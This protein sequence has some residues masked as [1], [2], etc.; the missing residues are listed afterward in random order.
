MAATL[1][2][3]GRIKRGYLG[4]RSQTVEI[5]SEAQTS[6]KREQPT[7]LLI[8]SVEKDSP[9]SKG[10]FIVGDILVA[11]ADVPVL[12]HDEL[13]AR[14]SGDVVGTSTGRSTPIE[15]LRGGQPRTLNVLIGER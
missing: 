6:L 12:H 1:A 5:P 4:V 8:V 7:G 14:L 9:A 11:V 15:I 2:K 13:F 10:G 3:H